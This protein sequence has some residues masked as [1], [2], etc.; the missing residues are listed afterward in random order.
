MTSRSFVICCRLFNVCG[1][2][3]PLNHTQHILNNDPVTETLSLI[4]HHP[5]L[6]PSTCF[7]SHHRFGQFPGAVR[8]LLSHHQTYIEY[9]SA[10]TG[11]LL[12]QK[13]IEWSHYFTHHITIPWSEPRNDHFHDK[14]ESIP[15]IC[16]TFIAQQPQFQS[17]THVSW[18][19]R[20]R[21]T[22]IAIKN[23]WCRPARWGE[24]SI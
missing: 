19:R 5:A 12:G 6:L 14:R 21:I 23:E 10:S 24:V 22:S 4:L 15:I 20:P 16:C 9:R 13:E 17:G 18:Y 11:K 8:H 7:L 2:I 1:Y 3:L